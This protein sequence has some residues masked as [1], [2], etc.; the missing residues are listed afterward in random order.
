M[1]EF[2]EMIKTDYGI[3]RKPITARNP[4][5][6]SVLERIHQTLGN[7][8]R[9]YQIYSNPDLEEEDPWSGI[10]SAA[11][12]A[13]RSTYHT[14]LQA[15]PMQLVFGRDSM[16]NVKFEAD[17]N[18]I[19]KRKQQ[20]INRN[21]IRENSKR[22]PYQYQVGEKILITRGLKNKYGD[23]PYEGP[24]RVLSINENGTLRFRKGAVTDTI[25]IR[26]VH[27]YKDD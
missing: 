15:T 25:I 5:A 11:M 12:F 7:I 26:N 2:S 18:L 19:K 20:E 27:P 13:L 23:N 21:N 8:L 22:L 3:T 16:L 4:Q 9:T 14:T 6:N 10:L 17:W 1:A 24:Y